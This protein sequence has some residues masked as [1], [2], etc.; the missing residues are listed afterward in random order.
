VDEVWTCPRCRQHFPYP[1]WLTPAARRACPFCG[2][3][4]QPPFPAVL[5]LYEERNR[6]NYVRVGRRVVLGHGFK[7]FA[8]VLDPARKP[9][10]TRRNERAVGHL[11]WDGQSGRYRLFNDEGSEWSARSPDGAQRSAAQRDGSLPLTSG[12]FVRFGEGRR[13]AVMVE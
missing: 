11:E 9:P 8:D 12:C 13:L 7:V 4:I 3:R 10:F 5:E 2:G 1:Y 6:T